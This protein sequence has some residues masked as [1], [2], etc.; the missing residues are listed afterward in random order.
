LKPVSLK[1]KLK[2]C[3]LS[4]VIYIRPVCSTVV[5][6][7]A[8]Q[9]HKLSTAATF[10]PTLTQMAHKKIR[11]ERNSP[12]QQQ[13]Q[14]KQ[15]LVASSKAAP[16]TTPRLRRLRPSVGDNGHI[17]VVLPRLQPFKAPSPRAPSAAVSASPSLPLPLA[18]AVSFL[19][20]P[21][22]PRKRACARAPPLVSP[23]RAPMETPLSTRRITRSL[24]AA[25][26]ASARESSPFPS[27][28]PSPLCF[29]I[30]SRSL[31]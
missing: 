24:A 23:R 27:S 14:T 6:T 31:S 7:K 13:Q 21:L 4:R 15:R 3:F 9:A 11:K 17:T 2:N 10:R 28:P 18:H 25:A 16:G 5:H 19:A 26:A 30:V 29:L 20:P 22:R 8:T 12:A 1:N